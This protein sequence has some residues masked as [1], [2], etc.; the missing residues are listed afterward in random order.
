MK[1]S[2]EYGFDIGSNLWPDFLCTLRNCY[3]CQ[4]LKGQMVVLLFV[5]REIQV[6]LTLPNKL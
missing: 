6:L 3:N 4:V 5:T 1:K 2:S